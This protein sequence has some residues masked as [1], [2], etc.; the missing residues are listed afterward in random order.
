ME[1]HLAYGRDPSIFN[2]PDC[3]NVACINGPSIGAELDI[4]NC[5]VASY[6][7]NDSSST[8]TFFIIFFLYCISSVML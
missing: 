4:F 2:N 5:Y 1:S 7:N 6:G 3:N 8:V